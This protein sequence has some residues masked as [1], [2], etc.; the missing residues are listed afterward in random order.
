[1]WLKDSSIGRKFVMSISG[2]ALVF[3]LLFHGCMNLAVVFSEEAY[4]TICR[5]LGA[6][7]YALVGTLGLAFLVLVH[8]SYAIYLTIQNRAARGNDRYAVTGKKEGV[9]WESENMLVLGIIVIGFLVL[10]LYNFW[11][12]MQLAEITHGA[13]AGAF[14]PQDGASYVIALFTT[15]VSGQIY[16]VLYLFW[17]CAL[18]FHLRHGVWSALHTIGWNNLVWMKR[19]KVIGVIVASLA[20]APFAIVVLYYL[21][22]GIAML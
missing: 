21:G 17:L 3:F 14:D 13:T 19:I 15:P 1:M 6:N 11:F 10:H 18:W 5:L 7:W 4:N 16:C 2:L 8:F 9:E 20:V 22:M 12:R